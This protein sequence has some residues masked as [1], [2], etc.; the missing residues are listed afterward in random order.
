MKKLN[1]KGEKEKIIY[2]MGNDFI[3]IQKRGQKIFFPLLF[4]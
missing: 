3:K 2:N 1:K 4:L